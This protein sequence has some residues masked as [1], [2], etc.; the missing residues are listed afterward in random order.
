MNVNIIVSLYK[1]EHKIER[2]FQVID[3]VRQHKNY[4][5]N[6]IVY[7]KDDSLKQGAYKEEGRMRKIP[8]FGSCDY[9][10]FHYLSNDYD[11]FADINVFLKV[12][13][14]EQNIDLADMF[15]NRIIYESGGYKII[16]FGE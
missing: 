8:N 12:N 1:D 2:L 13:W 15:L 5:F 9:A 7:Y 14:F 6:V 16:I 3:N 10:F 4:N 11:K